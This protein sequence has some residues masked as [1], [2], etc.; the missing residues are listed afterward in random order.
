MRSD[1]ALKS[2]PSGSTGFSLVD[3]VV[4]ASL[5]GIIASFSVPRFTCV[6]NHARATQVVALGA[7]LRNAA[8]AA[9]AQY[10]ASGA[11]ISTATVAGEAIE[12]KNGYPDASNRGI[13]HVVLEWGGFTAI[14]NRGFV[15][16]FKTGAPSGERCS[17][18]Y[19]AAPVPSSA[20]A[21]RNI[22]TS[23]C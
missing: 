13:S 17:V 14:P 1:R 18:T 8:E 7:S 2:V 10:L 16:F 3:T 4:A 15:T 20:A 23:G 21:V 19:Y 5:V 11:T 9:H 12:L 22:E 6:A